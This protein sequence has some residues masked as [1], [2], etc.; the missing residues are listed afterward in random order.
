LRASS[1][2]HQEERLMASQHGGCITRQEQRTLNHQEN[3]VN[4]Q[5]GR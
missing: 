2:R 3:V 1:L 5:I 4:R